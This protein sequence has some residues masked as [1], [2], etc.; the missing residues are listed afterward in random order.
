MTKRNPTPTGAGSR[1]APFAVY[2]EH[3]DKTVELLSRHLSTRITRARR[4]ISFT[5]W[6]N[7]AYLARTN[8]PSG[9]RFSIKGRTNEELKQKATPNGR[10]PYPP[11]KWED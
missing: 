5:Q 9:P 6:P 11:V 7:G 2:V 8:A 4:S 10:R 3:P 1:R